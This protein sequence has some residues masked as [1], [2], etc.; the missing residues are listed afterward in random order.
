[1]LETLLQ[2]LPMILTAGAKLK[3]GSQAYQASQKGIDYSNQKRLAGQMEQL[4]LA[5][6]NPD[7]AA[8]QKLYQ[9]NRALGQSGLADTIAEIQR[10]NRKAITMGRAPLLDRER[11]G[12]SIF[13]NLMK[14]QQDQELTNR[15]ATFSQLGT[16]QRALALPSDAYSAIATGNYQNSLAKAAGTNSLGDALQSLFGLGNS[17]TPQR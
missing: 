1:M 14:A 12:E 7:N 15:N 17:L 10:Q 11:G 2:A 4:A 5:Q 3:G 9:K 13:R 8:F 6:A 16:A